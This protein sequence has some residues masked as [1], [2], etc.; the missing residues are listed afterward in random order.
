MADTPGPTGEGETGDH[1]A[2]EPTSTKESVDVEMLDGATLDHAAKPDESSAAGAEGDEPVVQ[3]CTEAAAPELVCSCM[4]FDDIRLFRPFLCMKITRCR[5]SQ[6]S[7]R[8]FLH[9]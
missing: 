2:N 9:S 8:R 4:I 5:S 6:K 3:E 1:V 7:T